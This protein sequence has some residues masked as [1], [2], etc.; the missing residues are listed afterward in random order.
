VEVQIPYFKVQIAAF[1]AVSTGGGL[2]SSM[3]RSDES[4]DQRTKP[5]FE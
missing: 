3:R 2:G 5:P 1:A 4:T